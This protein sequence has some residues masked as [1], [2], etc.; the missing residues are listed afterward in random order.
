[1]SLSDLTVAA[2]VI[3]NRGKFLLCRRLPSLENGGLWEFPGGKLKEGES[4]QQCLERELEEELGVKSK[5]GKIVGSSETFSGG[6]KLR[7]FGLQ[8]FIHGEP[9]K[10]KDHSEC[11]WVTPSEWSQYQMTSAELALIRSL[12]SL[13]N[14]RKELMKIE[15]GRSAKIGGVMT[16]ILGLFVG[17]FL[18]FSSFALP[19]PVSSEVRMGIA[20][21]VPFAFLIVGAFMGAVL[22]GKL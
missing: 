12:E 5:A 16:S 18:L 19:L 3:E 11:K 10:L 13:I 1:M 21:G 22:A 9:K 7:L 4:L 15:I 20:A 8:T 2:A 17:M 14:S 6:A